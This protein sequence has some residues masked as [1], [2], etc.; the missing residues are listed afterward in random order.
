MSQLR[1]A[2]YLRVSTDKQSESSPEDQLRKC[3]EF[4]ER[5]G[6]LLLG[7][8]I[9]RDVAV[10]GVGEDRAGLQQMLRAATSKERSFDCILVDDTSRLSRKAAY[11]LNLYEQ[12]SFAGIRLVAVSQGVDS[13]SPQAELLFGVHGLIDSAYS[14]E[15]GQKTH[16]GLEG[17]ILR[18]LHA[19]GR[20][21]GYN[22][23]D[24]ESEK[25]R[26][27]VVNE[28][29][30]DVVRRIFEMS[31]SGLSLKTI[32]QTLNAEGIPPPRP[33]AGKRYGEWCPTAIQP[34]IRRELYIGRVWWNRS[35]W[36]KRPGTNKRV[37]RPRP[38]SEW[39]MRECP[40][41][42][43]VSDD[44]WERVKG[45]LVWVKEHYGAQRYEQPRS[46]LLSGFLRCGVCGANLVIVSGRSGS[47]RSPRY[48]CSRAYYRRT[49]KNRLTERQDFLEKRLLADLQEAVLTPDA[50]EYTIAEFERQLKAKLAGLSDE[51]AQ[52]RERKAQLEVEARHY[53]E[54]I[55]KL[56][57]LPHLLDALSA[58]ENELRGITEHLLSE[59]PDSVEGRVQDIRRFVTERLA[60]LR[61]LLYQDVGRARMELSRHVQ[62]IR[63][64]PQEAEG[65]RY[66]VAVGEWELLGGYPEV[67][68]AHSLTRR[69]RSHGCGGRI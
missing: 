47:G 58:R 52:M 6:W 65:E 43:I 4:A 1:C 50:V 64:E 38:P 2:A 48:G 56:G 26:R 37:R 3:V 62:E 20:A 29:E 12:L 36:V 66:Y 19:G 39:K 40:E 67:A 33:R 55:G 22:I 25:G 31:A 45:R 49:C 42:R 21:Y 17:K 28:A 59:D 15:L 30:A 46:Y 16:R 32:A 7:E 61:K 5:Q 68:R 24:A 11:S 18:G 9:Y 13:L 34:M 23:M 27:L 57:P 10:S 41:L 8:H 44:L 51:T 69:M 35:K 14:R 63:M 53:A 54:A 60:D